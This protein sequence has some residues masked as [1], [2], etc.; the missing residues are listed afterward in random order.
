[1]ILLLELLF[2]F[3]LDMTEPDPRMEEMCNGGDGVD[4]FVGSS[5]KAPVGLKGD[6][7]GGSGKGS[8]RKTVTKPSM[9][10]DEFINL[11]HGSDPV[12]VELNRL[13]NEVRGLNVVL[14]DLSVSFFLLFF[15]SCLFLYKH[16]R[17][18]YR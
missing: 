3:S 8:R 6:G 9:D 1:M 14:P 10:A 4:G 12:K 13:E 17:F 15:L 7:V 16:L 2:L 18:F 5:V 11:L